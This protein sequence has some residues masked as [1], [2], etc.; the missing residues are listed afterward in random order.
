[1]RTLVATLVAFTVMAV[2]ALAQE[3]GETRHIAVNGSSAVV[4]VNDTAGFG[5]G[6]A[7]LRGSPGEALRAASV[8]MR[9]ILAALGAAGVASGDLRTTD[10]SVRRTRRNGRTVGFTATQS[11]NVTVR[12][13]QETG[14]V[15]DAAVQAGAD[16]VNGPRFWASQ[17][18]GLYRQALAAALRRAREKADALAAEAGTAVVRVLSVTEH[19]ADTVFLPQDG[20]EEQSAASA[21][22]RPGRTRVTAA[23]TA[24]FEIG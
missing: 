5:T 1:M 14:E 22:V 4:A 10:V 20:F 13:I 8:Q 21:P 3:Q 19:G 18:G 12:D 24:V 11:V 17:T 6:V 2:P 15:I 16:R 9:R 7:E 23:L